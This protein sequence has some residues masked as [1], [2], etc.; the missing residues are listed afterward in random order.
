MTTQ[1]ISVGNE[2]AALAA[3]GA[4]PAGVVV[5]APALPVISALTSQ[6]AL[7]PSWGAVHDFCLD[8]AGGSS[9]VREAS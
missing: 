2:R 3:S 7:S 4:R 8:N 6:T 9:R 1:P 5:T